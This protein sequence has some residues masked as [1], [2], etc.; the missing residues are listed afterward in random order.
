V[1]AWSVE[2]RSWQLKAASLTKFSGPTSM[3]TD[4]DYEETN[5]ILT[6]GQKVRNIRWARPTYS[7]GHPLDIEMYIEH[8]TLLDG[9]LV[10][11][12]WRGEIGRGAFMAANAR[13]ILRLFGN[14]FSYH[15]IYSI[16]S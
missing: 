6:L 3:D 8:C 4:V 16:I 11:L 1:V 9:V 5:E 12:G 14:K 2:A 7:S 10:S 13:H 15:E